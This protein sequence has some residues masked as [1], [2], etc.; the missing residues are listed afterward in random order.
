[1][2]VKKKMQYLTTLIYEQCKDIDEKEIDNLLRYIMESKRI[3]VV[4][5]G[6]SGL[7]GKAF[8]MRLMHLGFRVYIVG[9]TV[10]P[11]V[12]K[13]DLLIAISGSAKTNYVNAVSVAAKSMDAKVALI[14][15]H[16]ET[17]LG[18][19]AD[20]TVKITGRP[21]GG[22]RNYAE[23]QIKGDHEPLTPLGTLFE[24]S[25]LIFLETLVAELMK[26]KGKKEIH[27]KERHSN[28]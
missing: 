27:M 9:E 18:R 20:C 7:V 28:V 5:A 4:G 8:G 24:L 15:S 17:Y 10:T 11:A 16:P 12:K 22:G 13:G 21:G 26:I 19:K 1:M 3:F 23:R 6:R 2:K 25:C 14:T